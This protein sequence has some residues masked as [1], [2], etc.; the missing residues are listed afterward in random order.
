[1]DFLKKHFEKLALALALLILIVSGI[2]LAFKVG[3]NRDDSGARTQRGKAVPPMAIDVFTNALASLKFP[4]QWTNVP[5]DPFNTQP[6]GADVEIHLPTQIVAQ[7]TIH[8]DKVVIRKFS[9]I[10]KS[11]SWD[12][13]KQVGRNFQINMARYDRTFMI[14]EKG[15]I[16][17]QYEKTAYTITD[18]VRIT[19]NIFDSSVGSTLPVDISELTVQSDDNAVK[20]KVLVLNVAALEDEPIATIRCNDG[21]PVNVRRGAEIECGKN[22]YKVFDITPQKMIIKDTESGRERTIRVNE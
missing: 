7:A 5:F 2:Y 6:R 1:M 11:Y 22:K 14:T 9:L 13:D 18:F 15:R 20:P 16:E 17:D 4:P 21:E 3:Q 8:L 10:F 12:E 19:T